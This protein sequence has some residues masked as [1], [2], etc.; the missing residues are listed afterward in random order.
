M[1]RSEMFQLATHISDNNNLDNNY[2]FHES[3]L[4][5]ASVTDRN[6]VKMILQKNHDTKM[7]AEKNLHE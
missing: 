3:N 7:S 6:V 5:K 1:S 4:M 2:Y